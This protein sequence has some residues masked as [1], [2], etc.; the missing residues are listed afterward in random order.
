VL[1]E[2]DNKKESGS[3]RFFTQGLKNRTSSTTFLP[4]KDSPD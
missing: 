3:Q 2:R 4:E 1:P